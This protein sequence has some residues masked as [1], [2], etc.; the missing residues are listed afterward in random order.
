MSQSIR[1]FHRYVFQY[2]VLSEEPLSPD[3][4]MS[5]VDAACTDGACSGR[6]LD[7]THKQI[8]AKA[9]AKGLIAQGSDPSFFRLTT[10]GEEID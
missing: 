2:E 5:D 4:S 7:T 8:K 3:M 1:T 10:K 9:A 6:L